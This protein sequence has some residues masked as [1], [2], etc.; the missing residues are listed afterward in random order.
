MYRKPTKDL[1]KAIATNI[2]K[3]DKERTVAEFVKDELMQIDPKT[4]KPLRST[5]VNRLVYLTENA[6]LNADQIKAIELLLKTMA[7]NEDR[8]IK[9]EGNTQI[10]YFQYA[11][12]QIN[13]TVDRLINV[14]PNKKI[15]K[16]IEAI[17]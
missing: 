14:T 15:K 16:G 6:L 2:A 3:W 7:G 10:N 11:S 13:E 9:T 12:G 1:K 4:K 17:I 5:V 8:I